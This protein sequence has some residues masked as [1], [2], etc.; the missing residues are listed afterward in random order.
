MQRGKAAKG[1]KVIRQ[2]G[3]GG[4]SGVV[5]SMHE[6]HMMEGS[7][8]PAGQRRETQIPGQRLWGRNE[9]TVCTEI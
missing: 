9:L 4:L 1:I 7:V 5:T 8:S 2:E 6:G 3:Q